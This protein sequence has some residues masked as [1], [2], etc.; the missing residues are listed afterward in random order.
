M[1]TASADAS[2]C[3]T[4]PMRWPPRGSPD[5]C[6]RVS[7]L[8]T[9]SCG[10][11][12]GGTWTGA[13][14]LPW[15]GSD[16]RDILL[17]HLPPDGYEI[18]A[19]LPGAERACPTSD[20]GARH[21]RATRAATHPLFIGADHHAPHP[22]LARLRDLLADLEPASSFRISRWTKFFQ[23][24]ETRRQDR[25]RRAAL[26]IRLTPGRCR[27]CMATREPLKRRHGQVE[28]WLERLRSRSW[29]WPGL[30]EAAIGGLSSTLRGHAWSARSSRHDRRCTA[31]AV[32]FA[33][34]A[35]H[36]QWRVR[37]AS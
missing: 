20:A 6:A 2:T 21:P 33:P 31:D 11:V 18:G 30:P 17:W 3:C 4:L 36:P 10:A 26:V 5:T 8:N 1:R 19:G 25:C 35:P 28:L 23:T 29:R 34:T 32:A 37:R 22:T 13:R 14:F 7:V 15:R 12:S 24:A 9:A 16:G 27:A